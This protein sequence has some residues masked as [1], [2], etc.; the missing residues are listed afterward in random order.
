MPGTIIRQYRELRNYSQDYV[1]RQMGISQNAYSKIENGITQLTVNHIKQL[2][3]IL[4]V[5]LT[6]LLKDDFEIR[7]PEAIKTGGVSR[8]TLLMELEK[9]KNKLN[10]RLP[11]NHEHYPVIMALLQTIDS[12]VNKIQ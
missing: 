11:Q 8:E 10:D 6:D 12:S 3:K 7:R 2:A 4:E 9:I 5:S 1:A